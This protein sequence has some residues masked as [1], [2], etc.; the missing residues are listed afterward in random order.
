MA[1]QQATRLT[2]P[3]PATTALM[4]ATQETTVTAYLLPLAIAVNST[5]AIEAHIGPHPLMQQTATMAVL[6]HELLVLL[7]T[8]DIQ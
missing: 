5:S 4:A 8:S 1:V 7:L 3:A 6:Q 2:L